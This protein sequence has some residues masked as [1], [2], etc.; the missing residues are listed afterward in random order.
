MS[1]NPFAFAFFLGV[2]AWTL[3]EYLLHRFIGHTKGLKLRFTKEHLK[4][5]FVINYFAPTKIKLA[6]ALAVITTLLLILTPLFGLFLSLSFSLG[7][8]GMYLM[9]EYIHWSIHTSSPKTKW[10]LR[11]RQHHLHHHAINEKMNH[12][13]TCVF[14]D[15][16]F[17]TL[18]ASQVIYHEKSFYEAPET[19]K[20]ERMT[21]KNGHII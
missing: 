2:I 1:L 12:G 4:H 15:I 11:M 10:G 3:T 19:Y 17:N 21:S 6:L 16:I 5:H 18:E 9:Y 13:V 8:T 7:F 14:W 20:R